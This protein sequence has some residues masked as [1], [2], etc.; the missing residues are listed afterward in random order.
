MSEFKLTFAHLSSPPFLLTSHAMD[1]TIR[2]KSISEAVAE[3][4]AALTFRQKASLF[5]HCFH[6][7]ADATWEE[8]VSTGAVDLVIELSS[9]K[10]P[11]DVRIVSCALHTMLT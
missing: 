5:A 10:E 7:I 2:P 8:L 11:V 3:I 6:L 1:R 9:V 4:R